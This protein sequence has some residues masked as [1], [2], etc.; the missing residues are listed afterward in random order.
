MGN[1]QV[2][3]SKLIDSDAVYNLSFLDEGQFSKIYKGT[4]GPSGHNVAIKV[5]RVPEHIRKEKKLVKVHIEEVK[6]LMPNIKRANHENIVRFLGVSYDDF[7][8]EV[9]VLKEFVDGSD[10]ATLL[11]N[12][13]LSPGLRSPERRLAVALGI[14]RGM[15]HLHN[16]RYPLVHGD[17]KSSD[18]LVVAANYTPKIT[19]FGLW[20]F[21]HFFVHQTQG[22]HHSFFNPNQA[23]EVILH[24]ERP[25]LFSDCW[26]LGAVLLHWLIDLPPWDLQDLCV[27]YRLRNNRQLSALKNAMRNDED[28]SVLEYIRDEPDLKFLRDAFHYSAIDR[29]SARKVEDELLKANQSPTWTNIAFHKYYGQ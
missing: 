15:S 25:T 12:P 6:K 1:N 20:D 5:P 16:M 7:R 22:D 4:L 9:W 19:N 17:F 26:S 13:S 18:V 11:G 23:P 29:L 2:K 28:P 8:K 21:K 14:A 27:R 10:L 3:S 24:K